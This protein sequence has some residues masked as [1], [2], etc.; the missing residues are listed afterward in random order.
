MFDPVPY[1]LNEYQV[2]FK[3]TFCGRELLPVLLWLKWSR[4][5]RHMTTESVD[6]TKMLLSQLC[7]ASRIGKFCFA[8]SLFLKTAQHMNPCATIICKAAHVTLHLGEVPVMMWRSERWL[9]HLDNMIVSF[10]KK[11]NLNV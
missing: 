8:N 9:W 10:D 5:T 3:S 1:T 4:S 7:I 2:L 11:N 6:L